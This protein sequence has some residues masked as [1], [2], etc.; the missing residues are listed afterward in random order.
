[1]S[2]LRLTITYDW[3]GPEDECLPLADKVMDALQST[4]KYSAIKMNVKI[5]STRSNNGLPPVG[6]WEKDS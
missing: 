5:S 4:A 6:I 3:A 1:M 2:H